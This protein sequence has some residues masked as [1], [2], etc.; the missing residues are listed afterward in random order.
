MRI[1]Y[2]LH[3]NSRETVEILLARLSYLRERAPYDVVV[4][5][6]VRKCGLVFVF[7]Y[8]RLVAVFKYI[9]AGYPLK[10]NQLRKRNF[11]H[12]I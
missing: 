8:I 6:I 11:P 10:K 9:K 5:E 4:V 1:H 3:L 12:A 7:K 2:L